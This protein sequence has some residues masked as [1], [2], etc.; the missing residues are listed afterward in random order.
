MVYETNCSSGCAMNKS[1]TGYDTLSE[2]LEAV[3]HHIDCLHIEPDEDRVDWWRIRRVKELLRDSLRRV[4][5]E[6]E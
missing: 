3:L 5:D 1:E 4:R 2:Q 6:Q